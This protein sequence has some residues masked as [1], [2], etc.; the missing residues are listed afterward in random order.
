MRQKKGPLVG[1]R[2]SWFFVVV[3]ILSII[4]GIFSIY[5]L[6][7][8]I[9]LQELARKSEADAV[10]ARQILGDVHYSVYKILGTMDPDNMDAFKAEY[11]GSIEN[12]I[13]QCSKIDISVKKTLALKGVY[14]SIVDLH[15]Q[16]AVNLAKEI[17]N[18]EA[19]EQYDNLILEIENKSNE[20]SSETDSHLSSSVM[21][22][23]ISIIVLQVFV[24]ITIFSMGRF[25]IRSLQE[26]RK[27]DLE[28][29]KAHHSLTSVL[30]SATQ[31]AIFAFDSSGQITL[32]NKGAVEML[33]YDEQQTVRAMNILH[34]LDPQEVLEISS[35]LERILGYSVSGVDALIKRITPE[36]PLQSYMTFIDHDGMKIKVDINITASR[37]SDEKDT[38]YL[39]VAK[40]VM[41]RLVAEEA[42][43]KQEESLRTTLNSIGDAVIAT[44]A[45]GYITRMNPVAEEITGWAFAEAKGLRLQQVFHIIHSET[46]KPHP[47]PIKEVLETSSIVNLESNTILISKD[48]HEVA[49]AD[50]GAPIIGEDGSIDGVVLVFRDITDEQK[51]EERLRQSQK[52]DAIGQ[53]AGGVAHDFN[54]MLGGI[55]N[56]AELLRMT[57][58]GRENQLQFIDLIIGASQKAAGLTK[59]L[60][61]FSRKDK[62]EKRRIDIHTTIAESIELLERSVDKR[63]VVQKE[64]HAPYSTVIGDST[65][66]QN[67]L[68]NLGINARDAMPDGGVL[69]YST[70]LIELDWFFCDASSFDIS[71]GEYIC[72]EVKDSGKGM[73]VETQKKIFEPFFTTKE[74]GKGT[75]LGLAAVYGTVLEHKGAINVYSEVDQGTHFSLYL[76]V[77]N[78]AT[79]EQSSQNSVVKSG[80]GTVLLVDDEDLVRSTAEFSLKHLGFKVITAVDGEDALVKFK[81]HQDQIDIVILDMIMPK[82]NG[83]ECFQEIVAIKPQMKVLFC[84][85]FT[86]D[87]SVSKLKG[88]GT[89]LFIQKPYSLAELSE[90][91]YELLHM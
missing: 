77:E 60:L 56:A 67:A 65:Q 11:D 45:E 26:K 83:E 82:L 30:D 49:V 7:K 48:G 66:L 76:P 37:S 54:N 12:L 42:L 3:F 31:V 81:E 87:I 44:D 70:K 47:N 68:I 72:V 1:L 63:I 19:R 25:Y 78:S 10:Y 85:G 43:R 69:Q 84:S 5:N 16:F 86:R 57:A 24:L 62:S 88:T 2:L 50:S 36:H 59:Q 34:F 38:T 89:H 35:E 29:K 15:Y 55:L 27:A 13:D 17:M 8:T 23:T 74:V 61:T 58:E 39:A 80:M 90:K 20:I 4:Q 53:L 79:E 46:R 51:T 75:G 71:P 33:G 73:D 32:F 64:C 41:D 40:N 22:S 91:I 21:T 18:S 9:N 52:M 28:I 6:Q 14:D